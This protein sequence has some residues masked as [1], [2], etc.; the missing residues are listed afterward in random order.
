MLA[1]VGS[2]LTALLSGCALFRPPETAGST[3]SSPTG[4]ATPAGTTTSTPATA[5][6]APATTSA[7]LDPGDAVS[8]TDV[9]FGVGDDGDGDDGDGDGVV[10]AAGNSERA[11]VEADIEIRNVSGRPLR[12]VGLVVD[13]VYES[14]T[15]SPRVVASDDVSRHWPEGWPAGETAV[16]SPEHLYFDQ[17][18]PPWYDLRDRH[19]SLR[20]TVRVARPL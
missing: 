5:T 4:T 1:G 6:D 11:V 14:E 17:D 16:L 10:T 7:P 12:R 9:T 18:G 15:V 2:G 20:V 8:V 13:A 19:Y 3:A